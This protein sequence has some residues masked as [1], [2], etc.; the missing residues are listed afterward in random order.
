MTQ[1]IDIRG[2]ADMERAVNQ[3]L[4]TD[5]STAGEGPWTFA[6]EDALRYGGNRTRCCGLPPKGTQRATL[7]KILTAGVLSGGHVDTIP[8]KTGG[9]RLVIVV[10]VPYT[11]PPAG[12]VPQLSDAA[13]DS[14]APTRVGPA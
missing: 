13:P 8:L 4:T 1:P 10:D 7:Q 11:D 14:Q 5:D 3:Y 6:L 2:P 9:E 12:E